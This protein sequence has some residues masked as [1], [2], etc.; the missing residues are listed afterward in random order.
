MDFL[1]YIKKGRVDCGKLKRIKKR[2]D[3]ICMGLIGMTKTYVR[4]L[5]I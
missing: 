2:N 3:I 1:Y 4:V 5:Q